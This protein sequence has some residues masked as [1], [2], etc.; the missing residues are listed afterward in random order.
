[1]YKA[2]EIPNVIDPKSNLGLSKTSKPTNE[3]PGKESKRQ[4]GD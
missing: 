3:T 1:L 2:L 4:I